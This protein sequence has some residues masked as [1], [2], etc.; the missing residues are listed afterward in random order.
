MRQE[1]V[2]EG[3]ASPWPCPRYPNKLVGGSIAKR[4]I[5]REQH[6]GRTKQALLSFRRSAEK[7]PML[8]LEAEARQKWSGSEED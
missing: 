3:K 6:Y 8:T 2:Y 4:E 7:E 5:T 1:T